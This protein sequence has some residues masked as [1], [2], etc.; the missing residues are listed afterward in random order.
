MKPFH[1]LSRRADKRKLVVAMWQ[2]PIDVSC[3]GK[4]QKTQMKIKRSKTPGSCRH[5][6]RFPRQPHSRPSRGWRS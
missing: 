2:P 4:S 6:S 3:C 5:F 1:F